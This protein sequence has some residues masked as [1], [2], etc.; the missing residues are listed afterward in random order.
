MAADNVSVVP[1]DII[2]LLRVT[3]ALLSRPMVATK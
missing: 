2:G 3:S 1:D